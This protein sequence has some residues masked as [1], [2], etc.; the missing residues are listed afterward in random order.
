MTLRS[1]AAV[2]VAIAVIALPSVASAAPVTVNLR[3]EGAS[4]T[5]FEGPVTTYAHD[6]EAPSDTTARQC[7]GTNN[8]ANPTPGA[9]ALTALVDYP[10]KTPRTLEEELSRANPSTTFETAL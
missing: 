8:S 2:A 9:T 10:T 4:Q 3:V 6:V 7:D 5:L 1:M